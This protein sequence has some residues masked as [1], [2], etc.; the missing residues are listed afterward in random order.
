MFDG[1]APTLA[2]RT[3]WAYTVKGA[4]GRGRPRT[5]RRWSR[6]RAWSR[7]APADRDETARAWGMGKWPTDGRD[8]LTT[9]TGPAGDSQRGTGGADGPRGS[10]RGRIKRPTR[11]DFQPHRRRPEGGVACGSSF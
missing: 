9:R 1:R 5:D 8:R 7:T 3:P 6:R 2:R 4:W 11:L 10:R